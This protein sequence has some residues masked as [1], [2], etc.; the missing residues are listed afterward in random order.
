[1]LALSESNKTRPHCPRHP[2]PQ[3]PLPGLALHHPT[4]SPSPS[5]GSHRRVGSVVVGKCEK[6]FLIIIN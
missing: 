2:V 5:P 6:N 4:L 3:L 1:M